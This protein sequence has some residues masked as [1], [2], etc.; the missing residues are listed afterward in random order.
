[1]GSIPLRTIDKILFVLKLNVLY[2][3]VRSEIASRFRGEE[4]SKELVT[5]QTVKFE[6]NTIAYSTAT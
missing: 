2:L 3:W 1:M 5:V 6:L 4:G